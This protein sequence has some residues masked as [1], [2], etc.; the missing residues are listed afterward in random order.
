MCFEGADK[1]KR[2]KKLNIID[3]VQG[4]TINE[5]IIIPGEVVSECFL[6]YNLVSFLCTQLL[7][8]L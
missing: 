1:E 3:E 7:P 4:T 6:S 5:G 2:K 8:I